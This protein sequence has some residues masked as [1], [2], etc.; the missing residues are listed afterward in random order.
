VDQVLEFAPG[1][2][3]KLVR[4]PLIN[5]RHVRRDRTFQVALVEP[6]TGARIEGSSA[7]ELRIL[8]D[9]YA[10]EFGGADYSADE[11]G[12]CITLTVN[13][14]GVLPPGEVT[15][16]YET[17]DVTTTAGAD[18]APQGGTLTFPR[19]ATYATITIPIH[20]D[21]L[22]EGDESFEVVLRN[23]TGGAVLGET[24]VT[25]ITIRDN[26]SPGKPGPG[27]DGPVLALAVQPDGKVLV[28]GAFGR[29][30]GG[31]RPG[32]GR[33]HADLTLDETWD[34]KLAPGDLVY[35]LALQPDGKVVVSGNF[36]NI[37]GQDQAQLARLLPDGGLDT[38]F[39]PLV[40][41]NVPRSFGW[42]PAVEAILVQPDG[43]LLVGG[44]LTNVNGTPVT[45][46]ARLHLD[47]SLDGSFRWEFPRQDG[48]VT[49]L[50]LQPDGK[51]LIGGSF[52]SPAYPRHNGIARL[53][54]DGSMDASFVPD[55]RGAINF[56]EQPNKVRG[57]MLQQDGKVVVWRD[58]RQL[59]SGAAHIFAVDRL[60]ANGSL[61][62]P[63]GRPWGYTYVDY[64]SAVELP[65]G[66]LWFGGTTSAD[67][68]S[69]LGMVKLPA[70][71]ENG[72]LLSMGFLDGVAPPP[73]SDAA[74]TRFLSYDGWFDFPVIYALALKPDGR[75]VAGGNFVSLGGQPAYCLAE[76]GPD[77]PPLG[78]LKIESTSLTPD[79]LVQLAA[80]VIPGETVRLESAPD[81]RLWNVVSF[82][83]PVTNHISFLDP[84][85][86]GASARF[87]RLQ[88][89]R[90]H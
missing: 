58:P 36:T 72:V 67:Y 12:R 86:L 38:S 85:P 46:L 53:H 54:P 56:F 79:G 27:A 90:P 43:R 5:D 31:V 11:L 45:G 63:L 40:L 17:R 48:H 89:G 18:Y 2:R 30:G 61:D 71:F 33:V 65:D 29:L 69:P 14:T 55:L 66:G 82:T 80:S 51:I 83:T 35:R 84:V 9:D 1:E 10:V 34:A 64:Y 62:L 15:V 22:A 60:N 23:P 50:A 3:Q 13:L 76:F 24:P 4:I 37:N 73:S 39:R 70:G 75:I 26:D 47:G 32:L 57:L 16:E 6:S 28:G 88:R 77:G 44:W 78:L 42:V 68:Y 52:F 41:P 59:F 19:Y 20:D 74:G 49:A 25:T 87:Y 81:L 7:L 21:A 8:N